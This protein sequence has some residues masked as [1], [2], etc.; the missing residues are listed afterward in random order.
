[1]RICAPH[2]Y[3]SSS[4]LRPRTKA[5]GMP[6]ILALFEITLRLITCA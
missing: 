4:S 6:A 1:M 2:C 3:D 5:C